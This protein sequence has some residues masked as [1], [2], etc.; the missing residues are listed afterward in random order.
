[1]TRGGTAATL[2]SRTRTRRAR[3]ASLA[4]A[5]TQKTADANIIPRNRNIFCFS[6]DL[7]SCRLSTITLRHDL[8]LEVSRGKYGVPQLFTM[9]E[10]GQCARANSARRRTVSESW[11][12]SE[13]GQ[14]YRSHGPAAGTW[15]VIIEFEA[16]FKAAA[17]RFAI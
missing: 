8:V 15:A 17:M 1:M 16:M 6:L 7:V 5:P 3:P 2:Y 10:G 9:G 14:C 11:M 13:I 4:P 12:V